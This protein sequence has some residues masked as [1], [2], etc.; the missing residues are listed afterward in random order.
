MTNIFDKISDYN[1]LQNALKMVL[2]GKKKYRKNAIEFCMY[3]ESNMVEIWKQLRKEEYEFGEHNQFKVFDPKERIVTAPRETRDKVVQFAIHNILMDVY[4]KIFIKHSYA[5]LKERGQHMAAKQVQKNMRIAE[6]IWE[7][8]WIVKF[9]VSKFFYNINRKILMRI[10][11]KKIKCRRTLKLLWKLLYSTEGEVGITLGSVTSQD[12]ANIYLN[13]L[14]QYTTR[15]CKA[16]Y[17]VR[18][19]DDVVVV[20]KSREEAKTLKEKMVKF[21]EDRLELKANL[22]KT[23]IFPIRQGVN[24]YGYKVWTTHSLVR[25]ESKRK[26]KRRIK[27][28]HKKFKNKEIR[29]QDVQQDVNSW[30][31]HARHS[32]SYNL[33]KKIFKNY[34]Y[35]RIEGNEKFGNR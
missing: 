18:Y 6:R 19:M 23:Q 12:M 2:K 26:M 10:L 35:I 28:M 34:K 8:P 14:D 4:K 21:I 22:K 25:N 33:C 29:V 13:E 9:D 32:N 30:L 24:C 27:V 11:S 16:R 3:E 1:N 17:Y 31:G 15:F 5:C 20:C 7:D